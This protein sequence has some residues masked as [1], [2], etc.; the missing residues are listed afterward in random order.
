MLTKKFNPF[1]LIQRD[2]F[3]LNSKSQVSDVHSFKKAF[4]RNHEV[5]LTSN[6]S[7]FS[8]C[9]V[10]SHLLSFLYSHSKKKL[11]NWKDNHVFNHDYF[12]LMKFIVARIFH[13]LQKR[14]SNTWRIFSCLSHANVQSFCYFLFSI[15]ILN[16]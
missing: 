11:R 14:M 4:K 5:F 9:L 13:C 3:K 8:E 2:L 12:L 10:K 6:G 15:K 7:S 16:C 1:S